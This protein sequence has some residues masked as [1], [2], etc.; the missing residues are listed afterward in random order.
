[1]EPG[2]STAGRLVRLGV[3]IIVAAAIGLVATA[4]TISFRNK[5]D[6]VEDISA[7]WRAADATPL[8]QSTTLTVPAHH[9]LVAFIVGTD[10]GGLPGTSSGSCA[11]EAAGTKIDLGWPVHID[12]SVDAALTG[13]LERVAVAGWTNRGDGPRVVDISCTAADSGVKHFVALPTRTAVVEHRPWFQPWGWI[14]MA[15][16]GAMLIAGAAA[17]GRRSRPSGDPAV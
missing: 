9:T 10:L 1:M 6:V 7:A 4:L 15:G 11:A 2:S 17:L 13:G 14:A 12:S 3:A 16:L 5:S 8:G